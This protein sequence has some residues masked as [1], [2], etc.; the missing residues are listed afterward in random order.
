M[1]RL[2]R[3]TR[4]SVTSG[5]L[6]GFVLDRPQGRAYMP[7]TLTEGQ[8]AGLVRRPAEVRNVVANLAMPPALDP[9]LVVSASGELRGF[10]INRMTPV[11]VP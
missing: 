8:L 10:S 11:P 4:E 6:D 1:K 3:P 2:G 5:H 9:I 7:T